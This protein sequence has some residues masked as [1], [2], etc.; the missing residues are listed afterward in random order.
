MRNDRLEE[1]FSNLGLFLNRLRRDP[2]AKTALLTGLKDLY[3]GLT[4]FDVSIEG[5]T[6]QVFF[7]EGEIIIPATRLSDGALHYLCLLAIL[8]DPEPPPLIGIEGPELGVHPDLLSNLAD[9]L[10]EASKR[11]QL[12]VTTH[13]NM[14]VDC[15][16]EHPECVVVCEKQ[17]GMTTLERLDPKKIAVWLEEEGL[18][19]MWASGGIGGVRW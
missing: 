13:S 6:V 15:F 8:C 5:G 16:S 12:I 2:K 9:L 18:G 4:D 7:T 19:M 14:I 17:D 10:V 11:C 3:A 1:D